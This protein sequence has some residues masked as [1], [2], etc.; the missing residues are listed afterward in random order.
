MLPWDQGGGEHPPQDSMSA[1]G[2]TRTRGRMALRVGHASPRIMGPATGVETGPVLM[3]WVP[4]GIPKSTVGSLQHPSGSPA[5]R[6]S[7][8]MHSHST[9][10]WSPSSSSWL[11]E[12]PQPQICTHPLMISLFSARMKCSFSGVRMHKENFCPVRLS[13]STTSVHWFMLMVP[14]GRVVGCEGKEKGAT[15][16]REEQ[17]SAQLSP[18]TSPGRYQDA[19]PTSTQIHPWA[20]PS[21]QHSNR[22]SP[23]LGQWKEGTERMGTS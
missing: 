12:E 20:V 4:D 7:L 5:P 6:I 13:P 15:L 10:P 22:S 21:K 18:K 14:C 19:L 17:K 1:Q 8:G 3:G 23:L 9:H 11:M 2:W 16:R